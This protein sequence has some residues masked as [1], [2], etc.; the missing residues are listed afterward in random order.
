MNLQQFTD[1][2]RDLYRRVP[3]LSV[4]PYAE[5]KHSRGGTNG[6]MKLKNAN[7]GSAT[8]FLQI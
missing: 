6:E 5:I 2:R 8:T 4:V 3:V 1:Y 7:S